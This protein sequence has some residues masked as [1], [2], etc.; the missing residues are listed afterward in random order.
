MTGGSIKWLCGGPGTGWLYVRPALA[1]RLVPA[2][3]GWFGHEEPFAFD[4]GPHRLHGG[5]R[6][7]VNGTPCIPAYCAAR[8]GF[9]IIAGIGGKAIREKSVRQTSRLIAIADESGLKVGSPRD[10]AKRGGTVCLDVPNAA[11]ACADLLAQDVLLDHRPGVGI[12]L[13]PHFYTRDDELDEVMKRV[14]EAVK[15]ARGA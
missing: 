3:T 8:P 1:G 5:D 14:R 15:R 7:F 6:R 2:I 4:S 12:R 9:A 13:A 10:P 11:A